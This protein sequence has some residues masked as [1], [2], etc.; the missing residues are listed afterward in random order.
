MSFKVL[1][2]AAILDS[3]GDTGHLV[4][5]TYTDA[6]Y[7]VLPGGTLMIVGG[8]AVQVIAQGDWRYVV[9]DDGDVP[10]GL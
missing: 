3:P 8:D 6:Y 4:E 2:T 7:K 5:N 1:Q 10:R 9:S